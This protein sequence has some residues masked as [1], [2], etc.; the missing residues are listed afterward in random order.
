MKKL[1]IL[2]LV[3][4]LGSG[5]SMPA[6]SAQKQIYSFTREEK[7]IKGTF[8]RKRVEVKDFREVEMYEEDMQALQEE[9][10]QYIAARPNLS[11]EIKN[12]LKA[13]RVAPGEGQE[14][15]KLLLGEPDKI[16]DGGNTWVYQIHK[17]RA[18]TVFIIPV[19]FVHEG[20][21]LRFKEGV[22]ESIE[23][24]YP[25]QVVEQGSAPGVFQ[26]SQPAGTSSKD[27]IGN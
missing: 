27:E 3:L 13:L 11:E 10:G 20:Y 24:H 4:I 14:E 16:I 25:R 12:N 23:R 7:K 8:G 18:I 9:V 15:V 6:V 22:L 26:K 5:C 1:T 21:Y 17:L 2:A 19:F